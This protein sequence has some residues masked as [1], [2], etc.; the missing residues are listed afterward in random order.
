MLDQ[1][2]RPYGS[3]SNQVPGYYL[4]LVADT[5]TRQLKHSLSARHTVVL[6][7]SPLFSR[8]TYS[9]TYLLIYF[10]KVNAPS[11]SPT[12]MI[13]KH[14]IKPSYLNSKRSLLLTS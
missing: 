4:D 2:Q 13:A 1:F 12:N 3:L 7:T 6:E 11:P 5:Q 8:S 9:L 14:I 10:L